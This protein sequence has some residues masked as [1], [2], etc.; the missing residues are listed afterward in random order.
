MNH[1]PPPP[2]L[3]STACSFSSIDL[4]D[5]TNVTQI[6][7]HSSL[8][9]ASIGGEVN[10]YVLFLFDI[11]LSSR[12]GVLLSVSYWCATVRPLILIAR[13]RKPPISVP[14]RDFA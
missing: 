12:H 11:V 5:K 1:T 14:L 9:F 7:A 6:F 13:E 3:R 8:T 10:G 2:Q 4:D